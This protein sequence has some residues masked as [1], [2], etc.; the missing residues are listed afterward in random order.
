[1]FLIPSK[2]DSIIAAK[3]KYGL[4]DGSGFLSSI[5]VD[6]FFA[7]GI[8]ISGDLFFIDQAMFVGASKPDTNLLYEF[9]IGFVI[10]ANPLACFKRPPIKYKASSDNPCRE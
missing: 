9:T 5:L 2:P 10:A 7:T 6:S 3:A 1:M 4:Q 8:L